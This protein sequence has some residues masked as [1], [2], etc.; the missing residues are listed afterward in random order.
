MELK[1]VKFNL[2]N[3]DNEEDEQRIYQEIQTSDFF[4]TLLKWVLPYKI[5]KTIESAI[6]TIELCITFIEYIRI[7]TIYKES[8][9]K[10]EHT[11]P[12]LQKRMA[13]VESADGNEENDRFIQW[14]YKNPYSWKTIQEIVDMWNKRERNADKLEVLKEHEGFLA[15]KLEELEENKKN[16]S[17]VETPIEE[18]NNIDSINT[19]H[20]IDAIIDQGQNY[21]R[22]ELQWKIHTKTNIK[23]I[24]DYVIS[25]L[26]FSWDTKEIL[27]FLIID[28]VD[29]SKINIFKLLNILDWNANLDIFAELIHAHDKYLEI[30][31]QD[32]K[33]MK[34]I[35]DSGYEVWHIF[36]NKKYKLNTKW[37][38]NIGQ[39]LTIQTSKKCTLS[40]KTIR[41]FCDKY[42]ELD[43][44]PL[45]QRT[46]L[47]NGNYYVIFENKWGK[48][49]TIKNIKLKDNN[50][51]YILNEETITQLDPNL[52]YEE[53][54]SVLEN[55]R[56]QRVKEIIR[57]TFDSN[58]SNIS[59][60]DE[61][62]TLENPQLTLS[63]ILEQN[64]E[65]WESNE[66]LID[67]IE[68]FFQF[69]QD[70]YRDLSLWKNILEQDTHV[71]LIYIILSWD[72]ELF[73]KYFSKSYNSKLSS[74]WYEQLLQEKKSSLEKRIFKKFLWEDFCI[75]WY[76]NVDF[77]ELKIL[78][79]AENNNQN[80][81]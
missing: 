9:R 65:N 77:S 58:D 71:S 17:L 30:D 40:S 52:S 70:K 75:K 59:N 73:K 51:Q 37:N 2:L 49:K 34:E 79:S 57:E 3:I 80:R 8:L 31:L 61:K 33:W 5:A 56:T 25:T 35:W 68:W 50:N 29:I 44:L 14:Y 18:T 67:K 54:I 74:I 55:K 36:K 72:E 78:L 7:N 19:S 45:K 62:I 22:E 60:I 76:E 11:S 21:I 32:H 23:K 16:T 27:P 47:K 48:T 4:K 20:N 28:F 81:A 69:I 12:V 13:L 66:E 15:S 39:N 24:T 38:L 64:E 43:G 41:N 6:E 1:S 46:H 10:R 26:K 63:E 42:L 53:V